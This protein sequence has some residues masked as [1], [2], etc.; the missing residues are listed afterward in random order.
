MVLNT[1]NGGQKG[2]L[3]IGIGTSSE[4][5]KDNIVTMTEESSKIFDLRPVIFSWKEDEAHLRIYGFIAEEVYKI[6]P[7]I[8]RDEFGGTPTNETEVNGLDQ[9]KMIPLIINEMQKMK[10]ELDDNK[11]RLAALEL[12]MSLLA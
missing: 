1:A 11:A 10:K 12:K 9:P 7:S 6:Y 4:K 3:V 5:F 2:E 8:T